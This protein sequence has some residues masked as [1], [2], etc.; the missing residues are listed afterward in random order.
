V[1]LAFTEA[2]YTMP[3][4]RAELGVRVA[5]FD[6][7]SQATVAETA[8]PPAGVRVKAS[9]EVSTTW[10]KVALTGCDGATLTSPAAG[11]VLTTLGGLLST[12]ESNTTSTQ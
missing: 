10:L 11:T 2:V 3:L 7:A 1:S 6:G 9:E 5:V 12:S 4:A 8:E